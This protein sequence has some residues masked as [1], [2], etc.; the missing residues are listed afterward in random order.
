MIHNLIV[1][2]FFG[3]ER[4]LN[5]LIKGQLKSSNKKHSMG[6]MIFLYGW[7][8]TGKSHTIKKMIP[9]LLKFNKKITLFKLE[10]EKGFYEDQVSSIN[11]DMTDFSNNPTWLDVLT[12]TINEI[13]KN[14]IVIIDE[15]S[16]FKDSDDEERVNN[17]I[18]ELKKILTSKSCTGLL[19][20]SSQVS[21][22]KCLQLGPQHSL[23]L[24]AMVKTLPYIS[25][26]THYS[27]KAKKSNLVSLE[28]KNFERVS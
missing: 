8:G 11:I 27:K 25:S 3:L 7:S 16:L 24:Y 13:K 19:I 22:E 14:N 23:T 10:Q 12:I 6:L 21:D 15:C 5:L 17:K 1:K 26:E 28:S 9:N 18:H 20:I 2:Y 4:T